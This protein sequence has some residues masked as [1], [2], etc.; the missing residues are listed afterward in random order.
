MPLEGNCRDFALGVLTL[1]AINTYL[2]SSV[3]EAA[4]GNRKWKCTADKAKRALLEA[5]VVLLLINTRE[6][7]DVEGG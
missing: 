4:S 6:K 3:A 7:G 1:L 5:K 2:N